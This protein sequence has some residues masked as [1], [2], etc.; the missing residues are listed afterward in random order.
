VTSTT[1]EQ[2][3]GGKYFDDMHLYDTDMPRE[4][5]DKIWGR[6]SENYGRQAQ[7]DVTAYVHNPRSGAI[8]TDR[9]LPALLKNPHVSSVE[10]ID[11]VTGD[12]VWPKGGP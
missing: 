6:L 5:A 7:G 9:E 12:V 1:L 8:Y 3:P 2:T 11:P 4:Q 10:Q